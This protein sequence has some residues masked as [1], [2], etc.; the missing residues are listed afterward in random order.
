MKSVTASMLAI[1]IA[2]LLVGRVRQDEGEEEREGGRGGRR[3]GG[4]EGKEETQGMRQLSCP[5][6]PAP[7]WYLFWKMAPLIISYGLERCLAARNS[8][9]ERWSNSLCVVRERVSRGWG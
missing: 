3:D 8:L 2:A 5:P 9:S 6:Y 7:S 4:G 1:F